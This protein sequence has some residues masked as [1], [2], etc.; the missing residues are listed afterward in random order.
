MLPIGLDDDDNQLC[1]TSKDQPCQ[2]VYACEPVYSDIWRGNMCHGN[3]IMSHPSSPEIKKKKVVTSSG[4]GKLSN[5]SSA[6]KAYHFAMM[7]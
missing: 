1:G 2:R 3:F 4:D 7:T 6:I 5:L